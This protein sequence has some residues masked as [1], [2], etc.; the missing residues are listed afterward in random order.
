[1]PRRVVSCKYEGAWNPPIILDA[2]SEV[3]YEHIIG[4]V[5][6]IKA[7]GIDNIE[8]VGN[9]RFDAYYGSGSKDQFKKD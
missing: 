5:N 4:A 2:D 7:A 8:F 6:A 3:P 1:M 9:P